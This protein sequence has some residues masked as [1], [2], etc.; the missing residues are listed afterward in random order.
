M[1]KKHIYLLYKSVLGA[2]LGFT[3]IGCV[4]S[5]DSE[6]SVEAE[7]LGVW[8][9]ESSCIWLGRELLGVYFDYATISLEFV[10]DVT[11]TYRYQGYDDES[12]ANTNTQNVNLEGF[13][14][15]GADVITTEGDAATELDIYG[16][17][18]VYTI[19]ASGDRDNVAVAESLTNSQQIYTIELGVLYLGFIVQ[20]G[21]SS[22]LNYDIP[23]YRIASDS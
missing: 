13:Y 15:V 17:Y 5:D 11:M 14:T 4:G 20:E 22:D 6:R 12:C 2:I 16:P 9:A 21:R 1:E 8:Q 10:D 18:D 7:I 23:Y 3:L 19:N